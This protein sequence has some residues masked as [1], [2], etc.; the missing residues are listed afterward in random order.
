M[1]GWDRWQKDIVGLYA[2]VTVQRVCLTGKMLLKKGLH[3]IF[4]VISRVYIKV[5]AAEA[6]TL[7]PLSR[8]ASSLYP[9]SRE[10]DSL[11]PLSREN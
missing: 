10:N 9:L 4:T 2:N 6:G 11:H 3:F 5:T 7:H 1:K 8:E